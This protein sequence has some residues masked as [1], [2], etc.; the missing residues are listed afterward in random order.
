MPNTVVNCLQL[1]LTDARVCLLD[2]LQLLELVRKSTRR[3]RPCLRTELS[4]IYL[5]YRLSFLLLYLMYTH[6]MVASVRVCE[7][8]SLF[9][10]VSIQIFNETILR[11]KVT[12]FITINTFFIIVRACV[13]LY[14]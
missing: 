5:G 13:G 1:I 9:R 3:H 10:L 6:S 14:S 12:S 4:C 2:V 11:G 7:Y 8:V